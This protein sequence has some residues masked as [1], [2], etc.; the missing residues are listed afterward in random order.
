MGCSDHPIIL[1]VHKPFPSPSYLSPPSAPPVTTGGGVN[2]RLH[3]VCRIP[4][5]YYTLE[6]G[7][8]LPDYI[9]SIPNRSACQ[10]CGSQI[11]KIVSVK[12][13]YLEKYFCNYI[14]VSLCH[15]GGW[16]KKIN[17]WYLNTLMVYL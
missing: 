2:P 6:E 1:T 14:H 3:P 16:S 8:L 11:P 7:D 5:L 10:F 9:C 17:A 13:S 15:G 12:I 4:H